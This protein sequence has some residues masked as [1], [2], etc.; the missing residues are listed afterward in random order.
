MYQLSKVVH[1]AVI[2]LHLE[3]E[4]LLYTELRQQNILR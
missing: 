3:P 2:P 1:Q 4:S